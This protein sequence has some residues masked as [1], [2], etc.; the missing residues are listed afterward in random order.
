MQT[1]LSSFVRLISMKRVEFCSPICLVRVFHFEAL[2]K[3]S[4]NSGRVFTT[5]IVS[6]NIPECAFF[7]DI[8]KRLKNDR[9]FHELDLVT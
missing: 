7:R 3:P 2:W 9:C 4:R 8:V 6:L 1:A 5:P